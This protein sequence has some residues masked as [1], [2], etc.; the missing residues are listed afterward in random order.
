MEETCPNCQ[1]IVVY[2]PYHTRAAWCFTCDG[3]V[4]RPA[5]PCLA[6]N[7]LLPALRRLSVV[8]DVYRM[9]PDCKK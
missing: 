6:G 7:S 8:K 1:S 5:K 9:P 2:D 3:F 4:L